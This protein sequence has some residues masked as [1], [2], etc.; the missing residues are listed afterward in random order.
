[1]TEKQIQNY[2]WAKRESFADL[3]VAPQFKKVNIDNPT[4]ASPSDVLYN[5]VISRFEKLWETMSEI[6]FFGCEVSLKEEGQSTMRT[7]FLATRCGN[8]GIIVIELKKS[9][10]TARKHILNCLRMVAIYGPNSHLCLVVILFMS[11]FHQ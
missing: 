8:D 11:L 5:M 7:D 2:I 6:D 4:Y 10:Q 9:D 3:L 1:M